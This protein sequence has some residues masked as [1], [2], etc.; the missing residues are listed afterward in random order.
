[1]GDLYGELGVATSATLEELKAAY[2]SLA[3][4]HHPDKN[5]GD[6]TKFKQVKEAYEVL[7][8]PERR[9]AY[10][11]GE[12]SDPQDERRLNMAL[13]DLASLLLMVVEQCP[14]IE[15]TN[16]VE[17]IRATIYQSNEQ[18]AHQ[19]LVIAGAIGRL[20]AATSRI[21]VKDGGYNILSES[22]RAQVAR[23]ETELAQ[24]EDLQ[25]VRD[26]MLELVEP[27]MYEVRP[28]AH[29]IYSTASTAFFG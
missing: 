28:Q 6:G 17:S 5:G 24:L 12:A 10:D 26:K 19:R 16:V 4:K 22:L 1:M 21:T 15:S 25:M 20:N 2:R 18:A 13:R 8:D 14:D 11:K 23:K 9:A 7:A 27:Y 29:R 3:Q